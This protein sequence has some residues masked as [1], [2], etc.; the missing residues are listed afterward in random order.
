MKSEGGDVRREPGC[1]EAEREEDARSKRGSFI[2]QKTLS[3][4]P[5]KTLDGLSQANK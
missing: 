3:S 2:K 4:F 1:Y 5:K